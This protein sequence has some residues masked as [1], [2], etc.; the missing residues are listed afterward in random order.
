MI[1]ETRN[2]WFRGQLGRELVKY[3]VEP[4]NVNAAVRLIAKQD[5]SREYSVTDKSLEAAFPRFTRL[6]ARHV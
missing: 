1:N 6:G 5:M 4:R 2:G 3:S